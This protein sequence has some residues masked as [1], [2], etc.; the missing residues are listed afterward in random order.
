MGGGVAAE[1]KPQTL[2]QQKRG[3]GFGREG[4]CEQREREKEIKRLCQM[5]GGGLRA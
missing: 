3:W 5:N 2:T 1:P 4:V